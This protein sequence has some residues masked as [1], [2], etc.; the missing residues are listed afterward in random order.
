MT[1]PC[2]RCDI[3]LL[4]WDVASADAAV[5]PSCRA[6]STV[7]VYPA[8]FQATRRVHTETAGEG[9]ATCFDHPGKRAVAACS[10]CGRYVCALCSVELKNETWCPTCVA[11]GKR[12]A[13]VA[14]LEN[15]RT[16]YDSMALVVALAPLIA[17]PITLLSA[18]A[19]VYLAIRHWKRPLSVVRRTRWRFV[20]AILLG[21][22]QI[23]GWAFGIAWFVSRLRTGT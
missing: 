14:E 23:S 9:E 7:R 3:L 6:E 13:K 11:T 16:L 15:A 19:A 12:H 22:A 2:N 1:V 20:A 8:M 4:S 18:P 21:L 5:C 17:W 10:Q